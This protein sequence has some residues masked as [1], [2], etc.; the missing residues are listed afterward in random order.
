MKIPCILLVFSI[1]CFENA[2]IAQS[3]NT[4][5]KD[6]QD[7]PA[8]VQK[9]FTR[10]DTTFLVID[11]LS[12]NP[13]FKMEDYDSKE[14]VLLNQST[15]LR[16]VAL[17][18]KTHFYDCGENN[19]PTVESSRSRW[20]AWMKQGIADALKYPAPE[21]DA[22]HKEGRQPRLANPFYFNI[23]NGEVMVVYQPCLP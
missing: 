19:K 4:E 13:K 18:K 14:P 22:H 8:D 7:T 5:T 1:L 9:V 10:N 2:L 21:P 23:K 17:T 16:T 12:H 15:K 20:L 3:D 11:I 6:W